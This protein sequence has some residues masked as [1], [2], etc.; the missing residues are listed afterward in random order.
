MIGDMKA[1]QRFPNQITEVLVHGPAARVPT[2]QGNII[3]V[4]LLEFALLPSVLISA[5]DNRRTVAI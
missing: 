4:Y 5:D 3:L 2:T 1:K